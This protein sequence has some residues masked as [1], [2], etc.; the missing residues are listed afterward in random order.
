MA[1]AG[2]RGGV[3]DADYQAL[4]AFRAALRQFLRF[5][6]EAASAVGLTAQQHQALLAVRGHAG[7]NLMTVGDLAVALGVRHHSA[8]GLV[9]RLVRA[10]FVERQSSPTDRRNVHLILTRKGTALLERLTA[11]HRE[12]LRRISPHIGSMLTQIGVEE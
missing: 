5:S 1:K 6:E 10:E 9:N 4:A 11:A 12:E 8:V 2:R 3:T 7:A